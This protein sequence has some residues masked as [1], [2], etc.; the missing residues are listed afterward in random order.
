[1]KIGEIAQRT[2]ASTRSLRYYEGLGLISSERRA[3]G[4]RDYREETVAVVATIKSLL[5]LGFSTAVIA[6]V[7]ACENR[8]LSGS[9]EA[10]RDRV[11]ELRD[12]MEA[13]ADELLRRRDALDASLADPV[14]R[15]ALLARAE[16]PRV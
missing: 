1:M 7:I 8:G 14:V 6:D 5:G 12:E 3:N 15:D 13:R 16:S 4:Y 2:G 10:V 11:G 9:C